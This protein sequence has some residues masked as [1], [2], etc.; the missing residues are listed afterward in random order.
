VTVARSAASTT[1]AG[2]NHTGPPPPGSATWPVAVDEAASRPWTHPACAGRSHVVAGSGPSRRR[3]STAPPMSCASPLASTAGPRQPSTRSRLE[4]GS[5]ELEPQSGVLPEAG[6]GPPVDLVQQD[7]PSHAQGDEAVG[8]RLPVPHR[9]EEG[10]GPVLAGVGRLARGDSELG[11]RRSQD[12]SAEVEGQGVEHPPPAGERQVQVHVPGQCEHRPRLALHELAGLLPL[13]RQCHR[14]EPALAAPQRRTGEHE[15]EQG[16]AGERGCED[17]SRACAG[18]PGGAQRG[19]GR[20][21]HQVQ[22]R[23]RCGSLRGAPR[24]V[25]TSVATTSS[26][27]GT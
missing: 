26:R 21:P 6:I 3:G 20:H 4:R 17:R 25:S 11:V 7:D 10:D 2:Q 1:S 22:A 19:G 24:G 8:H 15:P 18:E 9:T 23:T 27:R 16:G 14:V 13:P 12:V 5:L